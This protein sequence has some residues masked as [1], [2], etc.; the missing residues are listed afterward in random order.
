MSVVDFFLKPN[1]SFVATLL[2]KAWEFTICV[3]LIL[4]QLCAYVGTIIVYAL[5]IFDVHSMPHDELSSIT[6]HSHKN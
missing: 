1:C 6:Y 4:L 3:R 5:Q 2:A